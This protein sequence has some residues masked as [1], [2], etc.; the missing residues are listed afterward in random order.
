MVVMC[1]EKINK[2]CAQTHSVALVS[3]DAMCE[4]L[5][6]MLDARRN[7]D[8]WLIARTDATLCEA[9]DEVLDRCEKYA[10]AG[11]DALFINTPQSVEKFSDIARRLEPLNLPLIFNAVRSAHTPDVDDNTL[12]SLGVRVVLHPVAAMVEA[13]QRMSEVYSALVQR[14]SVS[15]T[16][17]LVNLT[18]LIKRSAQVDA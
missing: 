2:S 8:T 16:Q 9:A 4:R 15:S 14:Q 7:A 11:V 13:S 17:G 1:L 5:S 6:A 10:A 18:A 3:A 12:H